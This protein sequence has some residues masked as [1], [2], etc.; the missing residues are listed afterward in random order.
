MFQ[1]LKCSV[2]R[3]HTSAK[4]GLN[5]LNYPTTIHLRG[6]GHNVTFHLV[7]K[8]LFLRLVAMLEEFLD[9]VIAKDVRHQLN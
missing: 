1:C 7:R 4:H 6:E 8:D 5:L 9:H 3:G 2:S